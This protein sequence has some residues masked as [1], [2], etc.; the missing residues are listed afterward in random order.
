MKNK[1]QMIAK[2]ISNDK[3]FKNSFYVGDTTGDAK[4]ADFNNLR[5]IKAKYGYGKMQ[6]WD[7]VESHK[8]IESIGELISILN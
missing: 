7:S 6:N 8:E 1:S 3:G 2:I 4:A 5:F